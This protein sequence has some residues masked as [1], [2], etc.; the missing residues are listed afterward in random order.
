MT[1]QSKIRNFSIITSLICLWLAVLLLLSGC[2]QSAAASW[3]EQYDLGVRYL[4]EG[5]YEEA[6]IVFNAAIE[7]D[8]KRADAY[9]GLADAY[10]A[11]GDA[12]QARQVLTAA[13][14]VVTDTDAIRSR[15]DRLEG[16][17]VPEPTPESVPDPT[18]GPVETDQGQS[19]RNGSVAFGG[20]GRNMTMSLTY[21]GLP[22]E[23][24]VAEGGNAVFNISFSDGR[25]TFQVGTNVYD[26]DDNSGGYMT[27]IPDGSNCWQVL[28]VA[29]C[30]EEDREHYWWNPLN[31]PVAVSR[32]G[33]TLTWSFTLPEA[34]FQVSDIR[35]I[36]YWI[37][38]SPLPEGWVDYELATY[39]VEGGELTY[40]N[41]EMVEAL[42]FLL[43]FSENSAL[44]F[45]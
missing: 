26:Y 43:T 20:S 10:E 30:D 23:I 13:L 12:E 33:D 45:V 16:N 24:Y 11:Q 2:S 1:D 18:P 36:G 4:S 8:P 35:Y 21:P 40:M 31:V 32:S 28:S 25:Q 41:D 39:A 42:G 37:Y 19:V 14:T 6:I 17:A 9:I 44:Y 5:N 15:L 29:S 34:G 38:F 22:E 27:A 7:I 3:Q